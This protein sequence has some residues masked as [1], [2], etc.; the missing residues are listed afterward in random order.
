MVFCS[1]H[2]KSQFSSQGWDISFL[3]GQKMEEAAVVSRGHRSHPS[4]QRVPYGEWCR[5]RRP[6]Q[7]PIGPPKALLTLWLLCFGIRYWL[8]PPRRL[9]QDILPGLSSTSSL[10]CPALP[11]LA[12]PANLSL[13]HLPLVQQRSLHNEPLLVY[14][15]FNLLD[16]TFLLHGKVNGDEERAL[17]T[18]R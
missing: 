1:G 10:P 16:Q 3:G 12:L 8:A 13:L 4:V 18:V 9:L 17:P 2:R 7:S 15:S 5:P 14:F 11:L 6:L